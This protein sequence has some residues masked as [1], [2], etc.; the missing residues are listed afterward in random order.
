MLSFRL[1][2]ITFRVGL[3]FG[4]FGRV[5]GG[6]PLPLRALLLGWCVRLLAAGGETSVGLVRRRSI[7]L[8][9]TVLLG[10]LVELGL[11]RILRKV[12]MLALLGNLRL[13]T[14]LGLG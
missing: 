9:Q 8:A 7:M 3:P 6:F 10:R 13:R 4:I 2:S 11:R 14:G 5:M 1:R 12:S